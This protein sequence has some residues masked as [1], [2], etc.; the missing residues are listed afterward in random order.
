MVLIVTPSPG[1][2]VAGALGY[3]A[4]A[5]AAPTPDQMGDAL[6][7][8]TRVCLRPK[9]L[10]TD[11]DVV[12]WTRRMLGAFYEYPADAVLE[13][14]DEWPKSARGKFWPMEN[15]I[16]AICKA[17]SEFRQRLLRELEG[18]NRRASQP[19]PE[20]AKLAP[21]G[22]PV[23]AFVA[24][25]RAKFGDAYVKSWLSDVTCAFTEN[26][27]LTTNLGAERLNRDVGN[28]ATE[29]GVKIAYDPTVTERFLRA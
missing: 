20:G 29:C 19:L 12:V 5:C 18:M 13:A 25:V 11:T 26:V 24:S 21:E 6:G 8:I 28:I 1:A 14:F 27:V 22:A 23:T 17:K 7:V 9:D 2:D 15:D 10:E 16:H 4:E 3:V